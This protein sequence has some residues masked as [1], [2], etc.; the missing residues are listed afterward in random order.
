MGG[1][2]KDRLVLFKY[3]VL[4]GATLGLVESPDSPLGRLTEVGEKV[5]VPAKDPPGSFHV[6]FQLS[7]ISG[8]VKLSVEKTFPLP[9]EVFDGIHVRRVRRPVQQVHVV[10]P[11]P[12]HHGVAGVAASSVLHEQVRPSL[13]EG[14]LKFPLE[15]VPV[16]R[17]VHPHVL[18]KD[19]KVAKLS[20]AKATPSH[21]LRRMFDG[22]AEKLHLVAVLSPAPPH[23]AV[24][25]GSS[26]PELNVALVTPEN[27]VPVPHS[28]AAV[29]LGP[30][31]PSP[32]GGSS[33]ERLLDSNP[34]GKPA[35][36]E[37]DFVD[38]G[39]ANNIQARNKTSQ[40]VSSEPG[41]VGKPP[42]DGTN[43]DSSHLPPTATV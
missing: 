30:V 24:E 36:L 14:A 42:L 43:H 33:Q 15:N 16:E 11:E 2:E 20:V 40:V 12:V 28:A 10:L 27:S 6:G 25:A 5:R 19:D 31:E 32:D 38:M 4:G 1:L 35:P 7:Q 17:S 23:P 9:P 21:K 29:R 37:D 39:S 13:P 26:S 18:G 8:R 41:V 34:G 22:R 3:L